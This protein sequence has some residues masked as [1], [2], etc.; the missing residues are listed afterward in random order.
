MVAVTVNL[1]GVLSLLTVRL[2]LLKLR[3]R[4]TES[5][6]FPTVPSRVEKIFASLAEKAARTAG[7]RATCLSGW[8]W[9][10]KARQADAGRRL[11]TTGRSALHR[12]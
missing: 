4:K 5:G 9:Q 6:G 8:Q 2:V 3:D 11:R 12:E 10:G 7:M 1:V